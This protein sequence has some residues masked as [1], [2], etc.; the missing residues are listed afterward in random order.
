MSKAPLVLEI[1]KTLNRTC[2]TVLY[3][4]VVWYC[5]NGMGPQKCAENRSC[6]TSIYILHKNQMKYSLQILINKNLLKRH[7]HPSPNALN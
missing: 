1:F 4:D 2:L 6:N 3:P 5:L 7:K